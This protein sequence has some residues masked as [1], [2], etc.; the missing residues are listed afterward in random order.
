MVNEKLAR[1]CALSSFLPSRENSATVSSPAP[2]NT[3]SGLPPTAATFH[4]VKLPAR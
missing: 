1:V 4:N 3:G 2:I